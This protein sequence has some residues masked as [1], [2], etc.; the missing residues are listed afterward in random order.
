VYVSAK[1]ADQSTL[2]GIGGMWGEFSA[3]DSQ[4]SSADVCESATMSCNHA[5][6]PE[7][8]KHPANR[9]ATSNQATPGVEGY[10]FDGADGGQMAFW[11]Y[12]E[13]A[14]SA[15]HAH[16][17]DEYMIVVQGCHTINHQWRADSGEGRGRISH[18]ARCAARRRGTLVGPERSTHSEAMGPAGLRSPITGLGKSYPSE[19]SRWRGGRCRVG[20]VGS[21]DFWLR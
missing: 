15:T 20:D 6:F 10:V 18:P 21:P 17:Y 8:M 3:D 12:R 16:D 13:P 1:R 7:F 5:Q 14:A 2:A 9:I 19:R 4:K 11:I